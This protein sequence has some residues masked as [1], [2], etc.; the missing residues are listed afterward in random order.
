MINDTIDIL[1]AKIVNFGVKYVAKSMPDVNKYLV[2][3]DA[4]RAIQNFFDNRFFEL[5]EPIL[6]TDIFGVL[7]NVGTV[8]DVM[9]VELF[10]QTGSDYADPSMTIDE[11]LS[12]DGT[13][14]APTSDIIFELKY[15][16]KNIIGTIK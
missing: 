10:I 4:N 1:D 14:I 16:N 5:G 9:D 7:K 15:P 8:L 13:V 12:A 6:I 11:F 2:L 3:D